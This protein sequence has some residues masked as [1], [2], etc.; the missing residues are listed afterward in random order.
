MNIVENL[1]NKFNETILFKEDSN[2]IKQVDELKLLKSNEKNK[3]SIEK[4]IKLLELGIKGEDEI[5]FELKNANLGLYVLRDMT[6]IYN[7]NK[8]QI[9]FVIISKGYTYLV[10]CKNLIG[11]IY[12]DSKGQFQ[13]EYEY[14]NKKIKEAIYSPYT[15]AVRHKE[16]LKKIWQSKNN[17]LVVLYKEK[18][19]DN[20][21]YKPLVVLAN[22]KSILNVNYAP[23]EIKNNIVRVDQLVNY[24]KNDIKNYKEPLADKKKMEKEANSWL[25]LNVNE[26]NSFATKYKDIVLDENQKEILR[27]ELKQYRLKK[28]KT[29]NVPA[30]YIFTDEEMKKIIEALPESVIELKSILSSIKVKCHGEEIIK[31]ISDKNL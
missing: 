17:N 7:D 19:F 2:L 10:E 21:W 1:F 6:I 20:L 30:Y 18:Y 11:N 23:K 15:Q 8:A 31:I 22:S 5:L 12:V 29:M 25:E 9:D 16:V 3:A 26:Y 28:S 4:D 13:R 24:I 14:N 27:N